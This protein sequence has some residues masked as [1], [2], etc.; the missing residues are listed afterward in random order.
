MKKLTTISTLLLT[1]LVTAPT[2][3]SGFDVDWFV[4][5]GVGYQNDDVSGV[6]ASNGED[7]TFEIRSG[8]I[9]QQHHRLSATYGYMDKL[10]QHK[11]LTSYDYLLP[12]YDNINLFAGVSLGAVDSDVA[13]ESS[14]EFVWGGQVGAMYVINDNWTTEVSY[15]YLAQDFEENHVEI[16]NSQQVMVSVDYHF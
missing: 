1:A 7:A 5:A 3:S 14:T 4:G 10:E 9:L 15:R 13:N 2:Y 6:N 8:A 16:D 11:F 12:V